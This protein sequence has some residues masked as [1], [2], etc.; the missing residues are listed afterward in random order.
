LRVSILCPNLSEN[1]LGRSL[2]LARVLQRRHEVEIVGP[3]FSGR[4]WPPAAGVELEIKSLPVSPSLLGL[5]ALRR[6]AR[7]IRG[8]V[9]YAS[10]PLLAS[11]GVGLLARGRRP[12]VLDIDDWEL[13]FVKHALDGLPLTGKLRYLVSSTLR[14]HLS[15]SYWNN[16]IGERLVRRA[17]AV[18]VSN[19]FLRGRFGGRIV[20][21]G[22][23]TGRLDPARFDAAA[24]RGR[25]GLPAG[26]PVVMYLGT[27]R[28]YKGVDDLIRAVADLDVANALLVLVGVGE[29]ER[30]RPTLQQARQLLGSRLRCFGMQPLERVPEFLAMADV[31]A[32]PQRRNRAT[33]GQMPAKLFDAMAMG[34]PVVSTAVS[35]IPRILEGCGWVVDPGDPDALREAIHQVLADPREARERGRRARERCRAEY[36]WDAMERTLGEVF[37]PF[38]R[39]ARG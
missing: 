32:I 35:D 30:E 16:A 26:A 6:L 29:E 36:D 23:D 34:R 11:L 17:D 24:L 8:D 2:L 7:L 27:I 38:E 22:R 15:H 25:H 5:P 37:A 12:L 28:P 31:V 13:G 1:C 21:H 10:K 4:I 19:R 20:W 3:T 14:P 39:G 18:T 33:L 9:V